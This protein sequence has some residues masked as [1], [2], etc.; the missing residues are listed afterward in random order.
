MRKRMRDERI[1]NNQRVAWGYAG[2]FAMVVLTARVLGKI[3]SGAP[4][5][6]EAWSDAAIVLGMLLIIGISLLRSRSL[7]EPETVTGKP[8]SVGRDRTARRS[9]ILRVHLPR[10]L[11]FLAGVA[12]YMFFSP[13]WENLTIALVALMIAFVVAFPI[14]ALVGE[15]IVRR[16]DTDED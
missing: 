11:V 5:S 10:T 8:V 14:F 13:D 1:K 6:R 15:A 16:M 3:L 12:V 2:A 7:N 4:I 9:R